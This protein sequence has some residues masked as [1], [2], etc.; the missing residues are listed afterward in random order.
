MDARDEVAQRFEA[1][2]AK[3]ERAAAHC[4]IAAKHDTDRD[5]PRGRAHAFA[6]IGDME[7]AREAIEDSAK[8]HA[9]KALINID[10]GPR[11]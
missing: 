4:R 11:A 5:V 7:I 1:A 6:T 3:L 10:P 8:L 2:A 9:R